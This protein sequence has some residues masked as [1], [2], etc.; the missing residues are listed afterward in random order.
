M[1]FLRKHW[2]GLLTVALLVGTLIM[3]YLSWRDYY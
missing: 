2:Q 1:T 3:W